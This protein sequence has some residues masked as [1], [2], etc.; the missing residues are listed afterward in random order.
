MLYN[1]EHRF[2]AWLYFVYIYKKKNFSCRNNVITII[3]VCFLVL[4]GCTCETQMRK[5]TSV[6]LKILFFLVLDRECSPFLEGN[7][8]ICQICYFKLKLSWCEMLFHVLCY[9]LIY[10]LSALFC[11]LWGGMEGLVRIGHAW[12]WI[13]RMNL[14]LRRILEFL[15]ISGFGYLVSWSSIS[16]SKWI[17]LIRRKIEIR[18][19]TWIILGV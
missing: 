5:L 2:C 14:S 3:A 17:F 18:N 13:F 15:K 6:P 11:T 9:L 10:L 4:T 12:K 7:I 1:D 8:T 19:W 16:F